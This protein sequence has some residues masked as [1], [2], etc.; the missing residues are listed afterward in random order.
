[1]LA[2]GASVGYGR[3]PPPPS[4]R[5]SRPAGGPQWGGGVRCAAGSFLAQMPDRSLSRLWGTMEP[6]NGQ[7]SIQ[8]EGIVVRIWLVARGIGEAYSHI[9]PDLR[10]RDVVHPAESAK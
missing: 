1:R 5:A 10:V 7:R 4:A 3:R 6:V 8:R 2:C 9:S